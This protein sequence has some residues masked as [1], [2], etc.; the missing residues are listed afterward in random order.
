MSFWNGTYWVP[1]HRPSQ[2]RG[3]PYPKAVTAA[4]IAVMVSALLFLVEPALAAMPTL[5]ASPDSGPAGTAVTVTGARFPAKTQ[6]QLLW[7]GSVNSMPVATTGANGNFN[8]RLVVPVGSTGVHSIGVLAASSSGKSDRRATQAT[9]AFSLLSPFA[10]NPPNAP[11]ATPSKAPTAT[12]APAATPTQT[13][14]TAPVPTGTATPAPT[15]TP[16]QTPGTAPVPTATA[17]PVPTA[18]PTQTPGTA[19]VPTATATPVPTT[20]AGF[21][22]RSGTSLVL[23]GSRFRFDG[24]D[25]YASIGHPGTACWKW[26][27]NLS[28]ALPQLAGMEVA[29]A[30]AWQATTIVNGQRDWSAWDGALTAFAAKGVK[31]IMVLADQLN[32]EPCHDPAPAR[33]L[34]WYQSGYQTTIEGLTTYRAFV[35]E[36]VARYASNP[37]VMAW[38]LVNEGEARN[39]D[40]TCSEATATAALRSF[41]DDVGGLVKSLDPNHLVSLGTTSGQCGSNEADYA[42][43][44]ASPSIDLCD[45]HD[46]RFPYSPMGN[47]DAW[48]GLQVSLNRCHAD[49]KAFFVGEI[50]IHWTALTTPTTAYRATL[51][52]AKLAAQFAAGSV[53]EL[54]WSW[55]DTFSTDAARDY[56]IAPGDPALSLPAKY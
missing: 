45:Y 48:N 6:V 30:F 12:P 26:Q 18:T 51:L 22:K 24:L 11:T 13:P 33:T 49:G 37:A 55:S 38:Q 10:T 17:T 28:T 15:A 44:Y 34:A 23:D 5:A 19:P 32:A 4:I 54:M 53:G 42:N 36:A 46:Y 39:P 16:T 41:A 20:S 9:T 43:I 8:A 2:L 40:G 47:T 35:S 25:V 21:V 1:E 31:V 3:R 7:D 29:R 56:E 27:N 50:G 52:D 14:G